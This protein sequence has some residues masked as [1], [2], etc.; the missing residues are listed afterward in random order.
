MAV[1]VIPG[2]IIR[3]LG[4]F[5]VSMNRIIVDR[6]TRIKIVLLVNLNY[7]IKSGNDVFLM[8]CHAA[9]TQR[10]GHCERSK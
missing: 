4:E 3:C 1:I 9:R 7:P 8:P 6:E 5:S 10:V 2:L